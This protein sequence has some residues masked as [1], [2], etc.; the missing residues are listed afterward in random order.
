MFTCNN[1]YYGKIVWF[2]YS[3]LM[4]TMGYPRDKVQES[5][6]MLRYDDSF[7]TYHLLGLKPPSVISFLI[8]FFSKNFVN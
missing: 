1:G 3:A 7:A 2:I 6:S 5:L 4:E 8:E